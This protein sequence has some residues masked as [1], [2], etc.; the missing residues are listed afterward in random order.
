VGKQSDGDFLFEELMA[1]LFLLSPLIRYE[2]LLA[3]FIGQTHASAFSLNKVCIGDLTTID[4]R[5][6]ETVENHGAKFFDQVEGKRRAS[7]AENMEATVLWIEADP[8]ERRDT[9]RREE[10][11]EEGE[12]AIRAVA[13]WS[14]GSALEAELGAL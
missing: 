9:V 1:D 13:G 11:V 14:A 8:L 12:K 7:W 10:A 5:K 6:A 2:E 4:E 3:A